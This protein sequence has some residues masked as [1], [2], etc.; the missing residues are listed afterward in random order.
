MREYYAKQDSL[1]IPLPNKNK[2]KF[3][4]YRS[5]GYYIYYHDENGDVLIATPDRYIIP[6]EDA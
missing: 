2:T 1:I 5:L 4:T 3:D 6:Y